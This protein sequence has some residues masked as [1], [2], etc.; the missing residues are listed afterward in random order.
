MP[1]LFIIFINYLLENLLNLGWLYADDI[2]L[3]GETL[4]IEDSKF[5]QEDI[6][7]MVL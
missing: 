6:V 4:N 2:K 7:K 5:S 3:L 1:V